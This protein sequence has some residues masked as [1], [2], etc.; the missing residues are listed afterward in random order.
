MELSI[1]LP[2]RK[3]S[4]RVIGKNSKPFSSDGKSLFQ[5]KLEQLINIEKIKEIIISTNDEE[6]IKQI[7]I[8]FKDVKKLKIDIRPEKLCLSTTIV[9][10]LI[11]YVPT[12]TT[13]KY[14]LWVHATNP[15]VR[16]EDYNNAINNYEKAI[17]EGYDSIM[18]VTEHKQFLWSNS[19][20]LIINTNDKINKWPNTQDLEPLY[21][22]NHAFY[23]NSRENYINM[24][25]RIG[26]NPALYI[27]EG[28][29]TIDID[30]EKDFI[31]AQK[32]YKALYEDNK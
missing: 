18:S 22:I 11:D 8:N 28:E 9:K 32:V 17:K 27:L 10:D 24:H 1:F 12:I 2:L 23:I 19:K 25:D 15:F 13:C 6:I 7:N 4:Q 3:G 21:E 14:I 29:K 30:W 16:T 5:I 31:F 20:K 26:N